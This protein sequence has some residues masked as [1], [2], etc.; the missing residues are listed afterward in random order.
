M[1]I[2]VAKL[3]FD[4]ESEELKKVFEE[5]GAVSSANVIMDKFSG[6]SKGFGFVE[7]DDDNE[8]GEAISHLNDTELDGRTIVVKKAEP[9]ESRGS[10]G[11]GNR[12]GG[13]RGGGGGGN[14][15]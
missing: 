15:W 8:A 4:T 2:F 5:Y 14:R 13:N 9:R 10:G 7:M 3:S 11:G 1:N 6:K 12:G